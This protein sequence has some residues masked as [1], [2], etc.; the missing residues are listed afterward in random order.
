MDVTS[1]SSGELQFRVLW[2]FSARK[3]LA[4]RLEDAVAVGEAVQYTV[5]DGDRADS[6]VL[7]SLTGVWRYASGAF[8]PGTLYAAVSAGTGSTCCLSVD[9]AAWGAA[10]GAVD[11]SEDPPADFWGLGDFLTASPGP[12][13]QQY[14]DG[15]VI[16]DD[17]QNSAAAAVA[18][19]AAAA[20]EGGAAGGMMAAG[21]ADDGYSNI[22]LHV[23]CR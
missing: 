14:R 17:A 23:R 21:A 11:G 6:N 1:S 9:G 2:Q 3:S 13:F 16:A 4:Q 5:L 12:C 20:V 18:A 15:A 22:A 8:I 7:A 19:G 10:S